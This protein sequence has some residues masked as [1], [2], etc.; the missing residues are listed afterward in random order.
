MINSL[1]GERRGIVRVT[2]PLSGW[3][4][5]AEFRLC[6][7]AEAASA[8]FRRARRRPR[9]DEADDDQ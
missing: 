1:W 4:R 9:K 7:L 8:A 3:R 2:V 6:R 5:G